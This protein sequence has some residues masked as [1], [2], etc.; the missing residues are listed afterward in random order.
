MNFY[1]RSLTFYFI[2][3][4]LAA[5]HSS[6]I[7]SFLSMN[8]AFDGDVYVSGQGLT[9][10]PDGQLMIVVAEPNQLLVYCA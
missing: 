8:I 10:T 9:F 6:R 2:V 4:L 7:L 5:L 3:L 1:L